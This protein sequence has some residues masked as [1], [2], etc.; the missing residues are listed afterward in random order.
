M[1]RIQIPAKST[2][3]YQAMHCPNGKAALGVNLE[4]IA[5]LRS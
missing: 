5:T 3:Q 1:F 4:S 2:G